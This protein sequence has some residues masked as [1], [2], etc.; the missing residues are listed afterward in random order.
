M[1]SGVGFKIAWAA[2]RAVAPETVH[3]VFALRSLGRASEDDVIDD[4][5]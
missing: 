2:A 1:V 5:V 3:E 4:D